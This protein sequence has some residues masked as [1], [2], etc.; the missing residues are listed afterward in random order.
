MEW[1]GGAVAVARAGGEPLLFA[2]LSLSPRPPF[3]SLPPLS[4]PYAQVT[5]KAAD[6]KMDK[7]RGAGG[8]RRG[9]EKRRGVAAAAGESKRA[10]R[11]TRVHLSILSSPFPFLLPPPSLLPHSWRA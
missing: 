2:S 8:A 6:A 9:G 11:G 5:F 1:S 3:S 4:S 10:S 7:V